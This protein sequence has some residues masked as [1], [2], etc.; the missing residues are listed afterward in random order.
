MNILIF[1]DNFF[2]N[3]SPIS[4][5]RPVYDIVTGIYTNRERLKEFIPSKF[6][7]SLHCRNLMLPLV[8]LENP[9][10]KINQIESCFIFRR[11]QPGHL[12]CRC[13]NGSNEKQQ[14]HRPDVWLRVV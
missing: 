7:L 10:I 13:A 3:L 4:L 5:L 2:G 8:K 1:E 14:V 12:I 6:K 9:G 11:T